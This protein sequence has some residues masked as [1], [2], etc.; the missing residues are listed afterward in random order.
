MALNYLY[1]EK[2]EVLHVKVTDYFKTC[3][4]HKA[5]REIAKFGMLLGR[6]KIIWD[7][8]QMEFDNI[9]LAFLQTIVRWHKRRSFL[10]G[11]TQVAIVSNYPLGQPIVQLF[12]ILA[13]ELNYKFRIFISVESALGWLNPDRE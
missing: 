1:D 9:D 7:I 5:I 4:H 6:V 12:L 13:K 8:T 2:Y 10:G 11:N 3:D